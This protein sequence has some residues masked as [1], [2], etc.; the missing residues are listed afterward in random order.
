MGVIT[1]S[2]Q[3]GSE[4][5]AVG[6][7]VAEALDYL[8]VDSQLIEQ[9]AR[10]AEVSVEAVEHFDEHP[11][12][13]MVRLIKS[14]LSP[15]YKEDLTEDERTQIKDLA[16]STSEKTPRRFGL[17]EQRY[18]QIIQRVMERLQG[19]GDA[20]MMG[21]GSFAF[22][23]TKPETLHVRIVASREWRMKM[24]MDQKGIT[25]EEADGQIGEVD[26]QR[27]EY[28]RRHY[29]IDWSLPGRYHLVLNT[30]KIGVD[31]ASHLIIES[32]RSL[33]SKSS[34]GQQ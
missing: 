7:K 33:F 16:A 8:Y 17:T 27:K 21:R 2:R 22:L 23:A 4:G 15:V 11:E 19:R 10:E 20:V 12:N 34:S 28:I 18:L 3:F 30:G 14:F 5:R 29:K 13:R 9:V 26:L 32:A 1:I 6:K 31:T 25:R 24:I